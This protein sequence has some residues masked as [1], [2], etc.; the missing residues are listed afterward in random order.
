MWLRKYLSRGVSR[1]YGSFFLS[2]QGNLEFESRLINELNKYAGIGGQHSVR[3]PDGEVFPWFS[4]VIACLKS[5]S[6]TSRCMRS[7]MNLHNLLWLSRFHTRNRETNFGRRKTQNKPCCISG[8]IA[9]NKKKTASARR[10]CN[11]AKSIRLFMVATHVSRRQTTYVNDQPYAFF[12][13]CLRIAEVVLDPDPSED[14][15]SL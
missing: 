15:N 13:V 10:K 7:A 5:C 4:A 3:T 11:G 14:N 6:T 2:I 1:K 8:R 12:C 9:F